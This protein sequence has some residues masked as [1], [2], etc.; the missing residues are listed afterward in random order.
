VYIQDLISTLF[1][2]ENVSLCI[3]GPKINKKI[4]NVFNN[5]NVNTKS[6]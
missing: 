2:T 5:V 4:I 3:V 6:E 1:A